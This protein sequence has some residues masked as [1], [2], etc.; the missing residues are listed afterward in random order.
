MQIEK[1]IKDYLSALKI[2]SYENIMNLFTQD[3]IIHSP[4]YGEIKAVDFYRDLFKDT[5]KSTITLLNIFKSNNP[6]NGAGHFRYDW[7]LKDRTS[8]SFECVDVFQFADDGRIKELTIIYDTSEIR[9]SFE[10]I[11]DR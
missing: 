7:I 8:T 2:R 4:L 9:S 6:K 1:T 5:S 3:A 10:K 11:K